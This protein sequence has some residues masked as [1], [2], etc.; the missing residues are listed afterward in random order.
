MSGYVCMCVA[1]LL[2]IMNYLTNVINCECSIIFTKDD[3][4]R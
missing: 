3:H 2:L 4:Q 1:L